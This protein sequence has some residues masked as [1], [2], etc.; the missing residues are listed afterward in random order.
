MRYH[1][2][3]VRMVIIK[4]PMNKKCWRETGEKG[5]LLRMAGM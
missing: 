5:T 4:K 3:E 2:T 1:L